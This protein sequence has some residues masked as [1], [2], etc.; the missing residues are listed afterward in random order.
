MVRMIFMIL[1]LACLTT[2]G[3]QLDR[4]SFQLDSNSRMPFM[5]FQLSDLG[6]RNKEV[7][8]VTVRT[9]NTVVDQTIVTP[10]AQSAPRRRNTWLDALKSPER[11]S[12]PR[13]DAPVD[14]L[15]STTEPTEFS[16]EF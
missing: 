11:I 14:M 10:V 2:T 3:C 13:T 16:N 5:G 12:L 15:A 8:P 4:T 9:A 6:R 1:A 7:D